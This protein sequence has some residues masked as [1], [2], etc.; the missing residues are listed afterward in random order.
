[1]RM[2]AQVDR[3]TVNPGDPIAVLRREPEDFAKAL[4]LRF[5]SGN[6]D[7]DFL[8]LARIRTADG[9]IFELVRHRNAPNA[10]TEVVAASASD[11]PWRDILAVLHRLKLTRQDLAWWHPASKPMLSTAGRTVRTAATRVRSA[12]TR[13]RSSSARKK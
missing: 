5:R 4:R 13:R 6:D 8:R 3:A 2:D 12:G 1:M 7:L 11:N 9:R 10:G